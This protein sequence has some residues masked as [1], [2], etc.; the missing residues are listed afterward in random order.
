MFVVKVFQI[1][2]FFFRDIKNDGSRGGGE[3]S[4]EKGIRDELQ[5]VL[6]RLNMNLTQTHA[7]TQNC[8]ENQL[9]TY[10]RLKQKVFFL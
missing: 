5:V 9:P 3:N 2:F 7:H 4:I 6:R 8:N 10:F 1:F